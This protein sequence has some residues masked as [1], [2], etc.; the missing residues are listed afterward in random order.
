MSGIVPSHEHDLVLTGVKASSP[1][2]GLRPALTPAPGESPW[3]RPG[4]GRLPRSTNLRPLRF[5]GIARAPE[6]V[7]ASTG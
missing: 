7:W 3:H 1:P 6:W 5:Q 4:A 2:G